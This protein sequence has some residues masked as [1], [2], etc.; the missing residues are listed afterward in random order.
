MGELRPRSARCRFQTAQ[1]A[2]RTRGFCERPSRLALTLVRRQNAD[3]LLPHKAVGEADFPALPLRQKNVGVA[4]GILIDGFGAPSEAESAAPESSAAQTPDTGDGLLASF[5]AA[6]LRDLSL[7]KLR[8][9][10]RTTT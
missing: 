2:R 5:A 6:V 3:A 7:P 8:V 4:E 9:T 1:T 10:V